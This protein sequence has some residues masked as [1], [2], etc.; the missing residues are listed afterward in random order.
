MRFQYMQWA[1]AGITSLLVLAAIV[2]A[3]VRSGG[4]F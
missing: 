2:F 3:W 1:V 4:P